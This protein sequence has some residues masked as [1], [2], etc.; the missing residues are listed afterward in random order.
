MLADHRGSKI[1]P[2]QD[3]AS[4]MGLSEDVLRMI[5]NFVSL[6][7]LSSYAQVC[8]NW[9]ALLSRND[10]ILWRWR[11]QNTFWE[12]GNS[13]RELLQKRIQ[14][15]LKLS[16]HLEHGH[17]VQQCDGPRSWLLCGH[18]KTVINMTILQYE[19]FRTVITCSADGE[20]RSWPL[21]FESNRPPST[22]LIK[23]EGSTT[24]VPGG[25]EWIEED[26]DKCVPPYRLIVCGRKRV[27]LMEIHETKINEMNDS[28]ETA[29]I[30]SCTLLQSTALEYYATCTF[31]DTTNSK[32]LTGSSDATIRVYDIVQHDKDE[33]IAVSIAI[34]DPLLL[35]G[36]KSSIQ[37]LSFGGDSDD[38]LLSRSSD[39][40]VRLW[41]HLNGE[42]RATINFDGSI[43]GVIFLGFSQDCMAVFYD[44][45]DI[46][47]VRICE[48]YSGRLRQE[49]TTETR[50]SATY[51]QEQSLL[52]GTVDGRIVCFNLQHGGRKEIF[53][54]KVLESSI[55]SIQWLVRFHWILA[56]TY[57]GQMCLIR[58]F[59]RGEGEF[60]HQ[61]VRQISLRFQNPDDIVFSSNDNTLFVASSGD[62]VRIF[63]FEPES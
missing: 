49:I 1:H 6:S 17:F 11:S 61:I 63:V 4:T 51:L 60:S 29:P 48:I 52:C 23:L 24:F 36:H 43:G 37:S 38:L 10:D 21:P 8:K 47:S 33:A 44:S 34:Q 31:L 22:L 42:C 20:I 53:I 32:F 5:W 9:N 13:T 15:N 39:Q 54:R 25:V 2:Q 45:L 55:T 14:N 50:I 41:N 30:L 26:D 18:S 16:V 59:A 7:D 57:T 3:I 27:Y 35:N 58:V 12:S 28:K 46:C 40:T 56:M 19:G 62:L